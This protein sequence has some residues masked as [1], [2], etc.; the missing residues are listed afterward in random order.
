MPSSSSAIHSRPTKPRLFP[1]PTNFNLAWILHS[2]PTFSQYHLQSLPAPMAPRVDY[3]RLTIL[4]LLLFRHSVASDSLQLH[5]LQHTSPSPSPGVCS[6]L[7]SLIQWCHLPSHPLSSPSPPAFKLSWH[8]GLFQW[9]SS[10]HQVAQVLELQHQSFQW[11]TGLISSTIDWFDLLAVQGTLKSLLQYH[12]SKA[13][14]LWCST[15]FMVQ[16]S[17]PYKTTGKKCS[18]N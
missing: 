10:S 4:L 5:G 2:S 6:N 17:H 14:I 9:V 3:L 18:F 1:K 8:Q 13:L 12:N 11:V 16:L 7:C 15:F